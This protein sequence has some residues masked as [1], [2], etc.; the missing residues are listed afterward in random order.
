MGKRRAD[1][2]CRRRT[3]R[4]RG[5]GFSAKPY[6]GNAKDAS[7]RQVYMSYSE[8]TLKY[9]ELSEPNLDKLKADPSSMAATRI[10]S[11]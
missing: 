6:K 11:G 5:R 2:F 10:S 8:A 1:G 4:G 9:P 3:L 7:A